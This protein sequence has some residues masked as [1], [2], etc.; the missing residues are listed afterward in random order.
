M[1]VTAAVTIATAAKINSFFMRANCFFP[2]ASSPDDCSIWLDSSR[3]ND[4]RF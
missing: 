4:D 2:S 1:V 3:V